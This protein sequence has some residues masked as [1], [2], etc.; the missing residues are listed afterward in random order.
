MLYPAEIM[1]KNTAAQFSHLKHGLAYLSF[2]RLTIGK[3][4]NNIVRIE[5]SPM[6]E[7]SVSKG[8]YF[9]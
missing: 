9:P 5:F 6:V 1:P 4:C 7:I 8:H 2:N 3:F